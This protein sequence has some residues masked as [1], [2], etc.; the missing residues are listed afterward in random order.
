M[1]CADVEIT[2]EYCILHV[3]SF[4]TEYALQVSS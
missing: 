1:L 2:T 3:Y 4:F